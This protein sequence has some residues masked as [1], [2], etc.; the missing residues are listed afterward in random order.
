MHNVDMRHVNWSHW[1]VRAGLILAQNI[2]RENITNSQFSHDILT[3][4]FA[5]LHIAIIFFFSLQATGVTA[6]CP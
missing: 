1:I 3:K 5:K 2:M 4:F 6:L